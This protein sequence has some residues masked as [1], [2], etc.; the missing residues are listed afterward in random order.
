L[1]I[2]KAFENKV[3]MRLFITKKQDLELEWRKL[4]DEELQMGSVSSPI[5][6][7]GLRLNVVFQL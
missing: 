3:L 6:L 1:N 7:S 4:P 2:L 5:L